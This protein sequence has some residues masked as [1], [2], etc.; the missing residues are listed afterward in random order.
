MSETINRS[1]PNGCFELEVSGGHET[2]DDRAFLEDTAL[3]ADFDECPYC[4]AGLGG[5]A[6]A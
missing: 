6:R 3:R 1:C 4:G 5:E 2:R